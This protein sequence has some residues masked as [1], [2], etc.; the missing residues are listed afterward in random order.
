[1]EKDMANW[2]KV[3]VHLHTSEDRWEGVSYSA[4]ELINRASERGYQVLA[5]TNHKRVTFTSEL[6]NYAMERGILLLSGT[7]ATIERRHVLIISPDG[8]F[9]AEKIR[10]FKDI[11]KVQRDGGLI[12]APHP[13]FP[14]FTSLR[15]RLIQN[16]GAFDA[17]EYSH[18]Y[19]SRVN[20]NI[21]AEKLARQHGIPLIGTSDAHCWRQFGTTYSLVKARQ[22][23]EDVIRAIKKGCIKIV[24]HPLGLI[25]AGQCYL[26][27]W[28]NSLLGILKSLNST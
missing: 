5:I 22:E 18:F 6:Q 28:R 15:S 21:P 26:N 24:T 3:D 16:L 13:F 11:E 17:I 27:I 14:G 8:F 23:S 10:T 1:M 19:L 2:L 7:E 12:I 9:R 20:F 25:S 4:R